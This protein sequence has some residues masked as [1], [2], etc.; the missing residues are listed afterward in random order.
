MGGIGKNFLLV[1]FHN[2][3][4]KLIFRLSLPISV[5]I[6]HQDRK[7]PG[8]S[9]DTRSHHSQIIPVISERSQPDYPSYQ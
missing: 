7:V 3:S 1:G 5:I 9:P 6:Y 8:N 2:V 4:G